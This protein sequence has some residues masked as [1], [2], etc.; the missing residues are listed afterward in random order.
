MYGIHPLPQV[1]QLASDDGDLP[2][3]EP[4][5]SIGNPC[6]MCF[7]ISKFVGWAYTPG[8]EASF[9]AR[10]HAATCTN[11]A[12]AM[13]K[14]EELVNLLHEPTSG[15]DEEERNTLQQKRTTLLEKLVVHTGLNPKL[16]ED[17]T[18]FNHCL[19]E[20]YL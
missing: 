2:T 10:R 11:P 17:I 4:P 12:C 9:R 16:Q 18:L 7:G 6:N 15:L 8:L 19:Q 5:E 20:C 1:L 3:P 13:R 14:A